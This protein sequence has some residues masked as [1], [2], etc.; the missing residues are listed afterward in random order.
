MVETPNKQSENERKMAYPPKPFPIG[1]ALVSLV[2]T[3]QL[4]GAGAETAKGAPVDI[5]IRNYVQALGGEAA[6]LRITSRELE[7]THRRGSSA[8]LQWQ[9]PNKV[10]RVQGKEREGFDGTT[11]WA[12][13]KRKRI[14]RLPDSVKDEIETTVNPI[15]YAH[16]RDMYT[17]LQAGAP[18]TLD[19]KRM[20][21][22]V[23]PNHIGST[24]FFFDA[25]SHLLVRIEEFGVSSAYYKHVVEFANYKEIDGLML[26]FEIDRDSEEPGAENGTIHL[27]KVKQ[28]VQLDPSAFTRPNISALVS[29]GKR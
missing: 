18:A 12:E 27:S 24:K 19:A 25:A 23:A 17:D 29:G 26:P 15:R 2:L 20:D 14:K 8:R 28:N 16:L 1:L 7:A 22:L 10:L 5:V 4:S 9:A 21:V 3:V 6:I 11:A 13:S